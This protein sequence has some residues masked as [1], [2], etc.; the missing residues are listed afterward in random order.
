MQSSS[1]WNNQDPS[2]CVVTQALSKE[3]EEKDDLG[4]GDTM[5]GSFEPTHRELSL[6]GLNQEKSR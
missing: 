2:P 4:R 3:E 5:P 6:H 1:G